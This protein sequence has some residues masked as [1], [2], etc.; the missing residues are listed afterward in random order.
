[1]RPIDGH[2]DHGLGLAWDAV[3]PPAVAHHRQTLVH[4]PDPSPDVGC[5]HGLAGERVEG[6]G[7]QQLRTDLRH[8][9]IEHALLAQLSARDRPARELVDERTGGRQR[10]ADDRGRVQ[11]RT[12]GDLHDAGQYRELGG[13]DDSHGTA[14]LIRS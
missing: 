6:S 11:D 14:W 4:V 10:E 13:L 12:L 8:A 1:M 3:P 7:H 5:G 9:L 2:R